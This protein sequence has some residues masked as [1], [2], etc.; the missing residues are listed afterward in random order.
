MKE[1]LKTHKIN[2]ESLFLR[3]DKKNKG[4]I[5]LIEFEE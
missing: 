2:E 3:I 4:F 1:C 5:Q